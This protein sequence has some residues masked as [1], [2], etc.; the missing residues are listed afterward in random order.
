MS[1]AVLK[2]QSIASGDSWG[3]IKLWNS[4]DGSLNQ[5][6]NAHHSWIR[7]LAVM[8]DG[9]LV[10]SASYDHTIGIWNALTGELIQ[11][12]KGHTADVNCFFVLKGDK[13]ATG[14]W[15]NT[16]I[17]WNGNTGEQLMKLEGH[18]NGAY[19]LTELD[20]DRFFFS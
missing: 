16:I 13:I 1:V 3:Y 15:D 5:T 14:S 9:R 10:T 20:E 7:S 11:T 17:I 8:E 4:F 2:D 19:S 6:I 18:T 12:L